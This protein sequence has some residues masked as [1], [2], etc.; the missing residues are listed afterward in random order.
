MGRFI[1]VNGCAALDVGRD[2]GNTFGLSS[3]E[4]G[5]RDA[6][7]LAGHDHALALT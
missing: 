1:R 2:M 7:T 5:A 4:V 3:C 6:P